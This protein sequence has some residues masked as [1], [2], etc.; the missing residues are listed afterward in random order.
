MAAA[1]QPRHPK[2]TS[3][4]GQFAPKQPA[5]ITSLSSL[6]LPS[7]KDI[8]E[9]SAVTGW[10][11]FRLFYRNG[12]WETDFT[13][14][15]DFSPIVMKLVLHDDRNTSRAYT[16]Y[17]TSIN[18]VAISNVVAEMLNEGYMLPEEVN[19]H[20]FTPD[21]LSSLTRHIYSDKQKAQWLYMKLMLNRSYAALKKKRGRTEVNI[22]YIPDWILSLN[23]WGE[24]MVPHIW[25]NVSA[26][27]FSVVGDAFKHRY[28]PIKDISKREFYYADRFG[29]PH[30]VAQ[31]YNEC[32]KDTEN[33]YVFGRPFGNMY[34]SVLVSIYQSMNSD[35]G[36]FKKWLNTS[37]LS[38]QRLPLFHDTHDECEILKAILKRNPPDKEDLKNALEC[39]IEAA[40]PQ[41][42]VKTVNYE[43]I[44]KWLLPKH[45]KRV[46]AFE[47]KRLMEQIHD[48][49][50][51]YPETLRALTTRIDELPVTGTKEFQEFSY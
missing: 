12:R 3:R 50:H 37:L 11:T 23:P 42:S 29:G 8:T 13:Q 17:Q 45:K 15:M 5:D 6:S 43:D 31:L 47:K 49:F 18:K 30:F 41:S 19:E 4:G 21:L 35:N 51:N 34:M 9:I 40:D 28:S 25:S 2:G 22:P 36:E 38:D 32:E 10:A 7:P 33:G 44:G 46:N 16:N 14:D 20:T 48:E 39:V 26:N 27:D 1:S 24:K